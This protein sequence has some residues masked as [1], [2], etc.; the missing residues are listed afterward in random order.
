[1]NK[2]EKIFLNNPNLMFALSTAQVSSGTVRE[3]FLLNQLRERYPVAYKDRGDFLAANKYTIE[4]GGMH[5]T[6]KQIRG[7]ENAFIAADNIEF[8]SQNKIPLWLFG[9]LY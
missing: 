8:A 3:T 6:Q 1:M 7:I 4:V 9:F 5:K 2:P